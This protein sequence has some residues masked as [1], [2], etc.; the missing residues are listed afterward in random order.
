MP[1]TGSQ[2]QS[3]SVCSVNPIWSWAWA[4]THK[5]ERPKARAELRE[6]GEFLAGRNRGRWKSF[7]GSGKTKQLKLCEKTQSEKTQATHGVMT[8]RLA[9]H[10][11]CARR[12]LHSTIL[13]VKSWCMEDWLLWRAC[14][15]KSLSLE[16]PFKRSCKIVWALRLQTRWRVTHVTWPLRRPSNWKHDLT[17]RRAIKKYPI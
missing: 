1:S 4:L 17:L 8:W 14:H 6:E 5:G 13:Q 11:D 16:S 9:R 15:R 2:T 10:S 12:S 3:L 7:S